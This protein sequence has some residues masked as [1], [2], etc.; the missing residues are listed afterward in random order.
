MT[1]YVCGKFA[2]FELDSPQSA[3]PPLQSL[4]GSEPHYYSPFQKASAFAII[5]NAGKQKCLPV[6]K[7]ALS[8]VCPFFFIDPERPI[9]ISFFLCA[10]S[11]N[12]LPVSTCFAHC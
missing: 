9:F 2:F 8:L 3:F 5:L 10:S 11:S 1:V 12:F 4:P 7:Y 6:F